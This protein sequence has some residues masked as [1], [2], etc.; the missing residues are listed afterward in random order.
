MHC[1]KCGTLN[2]DT[3]KF[4][5]SCGKPL[6]APKPKPEPQGKISAETS[7]P[8]I[9]PP[10][11]IQPAPQDLPVVQQQSQVPAP[12]QSPSYPAPQ[13]YPPPTTSQYRGASGSS[14]LNIWGP[15]AGYGHRRQHLG[16]L[17]DNKGDN[18]QDLITKVN[19][20]F[21]VRKIPDSTVQQKFLVAR[22]LIVEHRPYFIL[23]RRLVT[24]GLYITKYGRDLFISIVSYLKP[25]ISNFRVILLILMV[26]FW[27]YSVF[28][29]P[30]S[31]TDSVN[32]LINSIDIGLFGGSAPDSGNLFG[33]ICLVGPLAFV[34]SVAIFAFLIYSIYKWIAERDFLAGLRVRPNEF[35]EDDL[36]ALEKAVEQTVRVSLDEIGLNPDDLKP[37]ADSDSNRLI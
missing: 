23:Q 22:G 27:L 6:S 34:N 5:L 19:D 17:M 20:K 35:N 31:L 13:T 2:D 8:K 29:F 32:G 14:F 33:L 37:I 26:L 30:N 11:I 18:T 36:M 28:I 15:F 10:P 4:C 25:P 16:W 21:Q 7:A 3:N 9:T 24:I 12:A 1:T